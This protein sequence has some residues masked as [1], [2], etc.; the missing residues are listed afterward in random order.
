M[1]KEKTGVLSVDFFNCMDIIPFK[2]ELSK[3]SIKYFLKLQ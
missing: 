2:N 3:Q 1:Q